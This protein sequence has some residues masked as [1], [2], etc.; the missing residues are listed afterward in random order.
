[1]NCHSA[2]ATLSAAQERELTLREKVELKLHLAMCRSCH[3]FARQI[4]FLRQS[5]RAYAD[6]PGDDAERDDHQ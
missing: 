2:T 3:N 6:R 4:D 5:M 1:M